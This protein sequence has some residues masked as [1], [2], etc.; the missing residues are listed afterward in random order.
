M[1]GRRAKMLRRSAQEQSIGVPWVAYKSVEDRR[2]RTIRYELHPR[3]GRHIYQRS[4][5]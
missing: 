4:K 3:C 5:R 1:N 2:G